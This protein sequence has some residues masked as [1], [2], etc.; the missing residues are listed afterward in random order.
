[1]R[2]SA[3]D[4]LTLANRNPI[5]PHTTASWTVIHFERDHDGFL[6][7]TP[8]GHEFDNYRDAETYAEGLNTSSVRGWYEAGEVEEQ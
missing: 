6:N 7:E 5:R 1:M 8:T 3:N 4:L 2:V